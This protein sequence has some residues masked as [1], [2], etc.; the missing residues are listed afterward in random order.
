MIYYNNKNLIGLITCFLLFSFSLRAAESQDSLRTVD[1]PEVVATGTRSEAD[2][3]LLPM[4]VSVVG[5]A[6]LEERSEINILPTLTAEVP[7]LFVTQ[8]G[9]LGY[10]VSTGG[11]GGIK[12]RGIGGSPNTDMLVLIDGLPQYA[13]LYGH[14]V[15]DN[16]QT[17]LAE[18][19]EVIRGP[20]SL[21]YGSNA[22]G[23]VVNIVTRQP[24]N[25][26]VLTD[27]HAQG[28]SYYTVD[29]GISNQF[30]KGKYSHAAGFNYSRTKGHRNHMRFDEYNGFVRLGYEM[31]EH[32]R[33]G[34]TGNV[35][36]FNSQNPGTVD[37]PMVDNDMHIL[38]GT[39]ALSIENHYD[40]TS[41]AVRLYYSGGHH[42]INDGYPVTGN[43]SSVTSLYHHTDFMAG[44]SLYQSVAFFRGN[45][46]TFGFDYQH[47]GGHAWNAAIEDGTKTDIIRKAQYDLAGYVDFRQEVVSWFAL[48]AGIRFDWHSQSGIAYIPQGGLSFLLPRDAEIKAFVSRGFRNPTIRELYMYKPAN[49]SLRAENVWNYELSYRQFLLDR[50]IRIGAN[51]FYLQAS[52]M[53]ATQMTDGKP[54][55]VNTGKMKN[56]G[57]E[58]EFSYHIIQGLWLSAN[59]SFLHMS[60]PQLGAPEH[61]LNIAAR[62]HHDRFRVGTDVQYI[63][64]LYLVTGAQTEKENYVLWNAHA[65]VRLWRGLWAN[66]SVDN[67]LGQQYEI[68][69][70]FPMP[71]TTVLAGLRWSF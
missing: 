57:L 47:F 1:L 61:K 39:A 44:V 67:I 54:K 43:P 45:R 26:T 60:N 22:M 50:R 35:A 55:N 68:N 71:G 42:T 15:A 40:R 59:Y 34:A 38:R 23:G 5:Q 8:R 9:V 66:I 56:C 32:W 63:H 65:A 10:G 11:S 58:A 13:G 33:I 70:G 25:D 52:N 37:A 28:G 62:Y 24:K 27:I 18:R 41:G 31:T 53:I 16:Y 49:D 3:R 46:T 2:P 6:Q 29:A 36:Y 69:K 4:T 7:G 48:D 17:M 51:I 21:F 30:R 14:P 20:A 12:V 19:V 64:G